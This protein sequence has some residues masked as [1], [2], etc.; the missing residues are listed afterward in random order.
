MC[1]NTKHNTINSISFT[2][3][4]LKGKKTKTQ[5]NNS[6]TELINTKQYDKDDK[7]CNQTHNA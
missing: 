1:K 7:P 5:Q 2:L 6:K 3:V 4:Q